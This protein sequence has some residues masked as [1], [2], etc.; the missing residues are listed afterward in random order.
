VCPW[1]VMWHELASNGAESVEQMLT[2][3]AMDETVLVTVATGNT[4]RPLVQLLRERGV[5]VRVMVRSA[6]D[7][8]GFVAPLDAVVADFDDAASLAAALDGAGDAVD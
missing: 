5:P 3:A 8:G 6:A 4:G 2:E 7:R 1:H